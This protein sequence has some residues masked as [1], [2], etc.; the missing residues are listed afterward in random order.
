MRKRRWILFLNL[1]LILALGGCGQET[2][3]PEPSLENQQEETAG[4]PLEI[5]QEETA[6]VQEEETQKLP[7]VKGEENLK[8]PDGMALF[9]SLSFYWE[10]DWQ[11]CIYVPE[12]MM[13]QSGL[14]L[15]DR[16][17]FLIRAE[18]ESAAY[19]LF[20]DTVQ[21]GVPEA[22][23][24]TDL[25]NQLHIVIR[26]VRTARYRIT[27]YVYDPIQEGFQGRQVMDGNGI[28]Y[29]GSVGE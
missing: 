14:M 6:Q 10:G 17:D 20:Q 24:W 29:L 16:C 15:D 23:V 26:D 13:D 28:N 4:A 25:E 19:I 21:L 3:P 12:E 9:D 7:L 1:S 8:V 27:D 5:R 18:Q 11:L 2:V 22:D